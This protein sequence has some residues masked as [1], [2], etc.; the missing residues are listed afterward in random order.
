MRKGASTGKEDPAELRE[1]GIAVDE[2]ERTSRRLD[3]RA[4][5]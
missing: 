1:D 2:N 5:S 3:H 4:P